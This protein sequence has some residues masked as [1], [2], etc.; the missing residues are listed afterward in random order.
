MGFSKSKSMS[1]YAD[2][3]GIVVMHL[4]AIRRLPNII[5]VQAVYRRRMSKPY[6]NLNDGL[7]SPKPSD[8]KCTLIM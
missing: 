7:K 5:F 6:R 3:S 8:K 2:E 4:L 1:H